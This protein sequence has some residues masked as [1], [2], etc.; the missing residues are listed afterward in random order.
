MIKQIWSN[1]L[2]YSQEKKYYHL[3]MLD[4]YELSY[5]KNINQRRIIDNSKYIKRKKKKREKQREWE[6]GHSTTLMVKTTPMHEQSSP[7]LRICRNVLH[8]NWDIYCAL[9][10]TVVQQQTES[11]SD[12][13]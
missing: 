7:L 10:P 9:A 11:N 8:L 3:N 5:K 1:G 6:G 2:T 4:T 13:G 12:F